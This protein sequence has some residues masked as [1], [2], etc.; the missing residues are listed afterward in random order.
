M[1]RL[2]R[3]AAAGLLTIVLCLGVSVG[4]VRADDRD[5]VD[6]TVTAV[7]G[8]TE[9]APSRPE[10]TETSPAESSP[11][12]TAPPSAPVTPAVELPDLQL[13]VWF[14]KPSYGMTD[15]ITAHASVTNAGSTTANGV[16]VSSTGNLTN[17]GW[18]P[19]FP[20]GVP[21]APGETIERAVTGF[22]STAEDAVRLVVTTYQW[23]GAPDANPEDNTVSASVPIVVVYGHYRGVVFG[24]SNGNHAEDPGEALAGITVHIYGGPHPLFIDRRETTGADGTF[25]FR[26][27]P[28]GRYY[29]DTE[30]ND[31]R[32]YL[33]NVVADVKGP[34]DPDVL[35]RAVPRVGRS[36]AVSL[37]FTQQSYRVNDTATAILTLTNTS[38]VL[39]SDLAA[40][41]SIPN[42]HPDG[43]DAGPLTPGKEG[44]TL[45]AA[46]TREFPITVPI[47]K[48]AQRI[49]RVH[50]ECKVGAPPGNGPLE[51]FSATASVPGGVATRV[52]GTLFVVPD[53]P[54]PPLWGVPGPGVKLYLRNP[55]SGSVVAGAV[56]DADGRF[57]FCNLPAGTYSIGV[58][59]PWRLHHT[60]EML[61]QDEENGFPSHPVYVLPGPY[62]PDPGP[63]GTWSGCGSPPPA[64]APPAAA[65]D[66]AATGA[67]VTR[68]ALSGL[69]TLLI[70]TGLVLIAR[71]RPNG[72]GSRRT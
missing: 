36:L 57:S 10:P 11:T 41:C 42:H 51:V 68:L 18:Y 45:P 23:S 48:G 6:P 22:I 14:D 44:V 52:T 69:L 26:D 27:L 17:H 30:V 38:T 4:P 72:P 40:D 19:A 47:G 7:P 50:L 1:S 66:L 9:T 55:A 56:T 5:P 29:A 15:E 49:G 20:S 28:A 67:G 64:A 70:G 21:V 12:E 71:Q 37:T 59:G 61:A 16:V 53:V 33:P 65:P 54:R 31:S 3:S 8:P 2:P 34:G 25:L 43:V 63:G 39:F 46:T 32:W 58:V 35:L 13:R 24:D 60:L 62:Q